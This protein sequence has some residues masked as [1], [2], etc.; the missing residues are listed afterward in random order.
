MSPTFSPGAHL[1][2][3]EIKSQLGAVGMGDVCLAQDTKL[4]HKV[5]LSLQRRP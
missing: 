4:D 1:G 3:H 5:A 2:R